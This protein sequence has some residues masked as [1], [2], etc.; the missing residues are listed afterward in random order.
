[1]ETFNLEYASLKIRLL[2]SCAFRNPV[3]YQQC[4]FYF[5]E[6]KTQTFSIFCIFI[7][8]LIAAFISFAVS[9]IFMSNNACFIQ[10]HFNIIP[11]VR[12]IIPTFLDA[13][14]IATRTN[15]WALLRQ[16]MASMCFRL[17]LDLDGLILVL[18]FHIFC[19]P[20]LK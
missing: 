16:F 6:F 20:L 7:Y 12:Y 9:V 11:Q 10:Y 14:S 1:M 13:L 15:L 4:F 8:Y 5:C 19:Q 2:D 3:H 17:R 18:S